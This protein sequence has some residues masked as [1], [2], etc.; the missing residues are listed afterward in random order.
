MLLTWR[1][2]E[3]QKWGVLVCACVLPCVKVWFVEDAG[4]GELGR[5]GAP[6]PPLKLWPPRPR[7][8]GWRPAPQQGMGDREAWPEGVHWAPAQDKNTYVQ[9]S[10][11]N[12]II[13]SEVDPQDETS[14][15]DSNMN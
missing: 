1:V 4:V 10:K 2:E 9:C 6:V 11:N 5:P 3:V 14:G 8:L 12:E 7:T 15:A 13:N